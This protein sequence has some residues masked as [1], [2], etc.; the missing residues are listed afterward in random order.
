MRGLEDRPQA[1]RGWLVRRFVARMHCGTGPH[2]IP[3]IERVTSAPSSHPSHGTSQ[4]GHTTVVRS[5]FPSDG[6]SNARDF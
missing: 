6:E 1:N 2:R 4:F 5:S 3:R